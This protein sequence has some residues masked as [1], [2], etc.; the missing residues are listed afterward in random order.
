MQKKILFHIVVFIAAA[1]VMWGALI[2]T[3]LIP[4]EKI[5]DNMLKSAESYAGVDA[6]SFENG[7]KFNAAADNYAD[8]I[9]LNIMWNIDSGEPLRSS[10]DTKYYN[11]EQLGENWGLYTSVR[12]SEKPNTDY[13][14]Y[15]H[16]SVI[17]IRPLMLFTDVSG[18]KMVGFCAVIILA[19]AVCAVLIKRRQCFAA[20]AF[21]L[22]L[23]CVQVYNV[24]LALEYI[25]IFL[26]A[27]TACLCFICL[28]KKGDLSLTLLS[29][30]FGAAAAFFDFLTAETLSILLPL[31]LVMIIREQENRLGKLKENIT[32]IAK[33]IACWGVSYA[34]TFILKWTLATAVTGENKFKAAIEYA[35]M[36][37]GLSGETE[38]MPFIK[39]LFFA[40]LAN[41]STMFGGESRVDGAKIVIGLFLALV[42]FGGTYG[43]LI[44]RTANKPIAAVCL[45]LGAVP[46]LRFLVL[47]NHSYLHEFFT[48]RAQAAT[49]L[50]LCAA[51]WFNTELSV[52]KKSKK[53]KSKRR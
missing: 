17:F 8:T 27:L 22:S 29:V 28:E 48:Y 41:L 16:G 4:N 45:I 30:I 46:Y 12:N 35:G 36:R 25:P 21:S 19:L 13:T 38:E 10:L 11:G 32:L 37:A 15:W 1:A 18:V 49:V 20:A 44:R 33:C 53:N 42:I 5:Y 7:D 6:F 2:L 39:Q 24:R 26:V 51:V 47:S 52:K 50:A 3:S 9:L 23:L 14:R 40:P 31:L 34:M 43:L